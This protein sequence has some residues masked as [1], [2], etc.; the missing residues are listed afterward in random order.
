MSAARG[1][2]RTW[3]LV[4]I[5]ALAAGIGGVFLAGRESDPAQKSGSGEPGAPTGEPVLAPLLDPALAALPPRPSS[6]PDAASLA[7]EWRVL[8]GTLAVGTGK[9]AVVMPALSD[10]TRAVAIAVEGGGVTAR[11][12]PGDAVFPLR[13]DGA[14][15][16][17]ARRDQ[18]GT[19]ITME[20]REAGAELSVAVRSAD[21][22]PTTWGFRAARGK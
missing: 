15:W 21:P 19:E 10:G 1:S 17:G 8:D 2:A 3:G 20:V 18:E 14:A 16:T 7:G 5:A 4:G 11:L 6:P 13:A 9:D 12:L 22:E